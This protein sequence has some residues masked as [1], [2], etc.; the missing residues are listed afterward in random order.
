MLQQTWGSTHS[1]VGMSDLGPSFPTASGANQKVE[2]IDRIK[3]AVRSAKKGQELLS[4]LNQR[5]GGD[6]T[7]ETSSS[8]SLLSSSASS[9][10]SAVAS[11]SSSSSSSSSPSSSSFLRFPPVVPHPPL[12]PAS[13][14][15]AA[16]APATSIVGG[17]NVGA[18]AAEEAIQ[19]APKRE[20]IQ[21]APKRGNGK[22]MKDK[23]KRAPRKCQRCVQYE[24]LYKSSSIN[25]H[26]A[27]CKGRW[28]V[29][30]CEYFND[31]GSPKT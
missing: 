4:A 8:L 28:S 7:T 11:S 29:G 12:L 6:I 22:R 16:A 23:S 30:T 21:T 15:V 5:T 20:V 25:Q 14:S 27:T 24:R 19:T 3:D 13:A 31:N 1:L 2:R 26:A 17:T 9:S 18:A 10:S